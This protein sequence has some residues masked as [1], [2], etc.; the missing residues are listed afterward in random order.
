MA[1]AENTLR[2]QISTPAEGTLWR[3]EGTSLSSENS[4]GPFDILWG[5]ANFITIIHEKPI[6]IRQDKNVIK[7][8]TPQT[9]V[10]YVKGSEVK[11][12][13]EI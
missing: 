7:K 4:Q 9:A 13:T 12:Y 1:K 5:H 8:L 2:I 11:V 3:G 10:I 6:V